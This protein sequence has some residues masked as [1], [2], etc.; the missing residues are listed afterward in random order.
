[1]F[2]HTSG[3][4]G[5]GARNQ[6]VVAHTLIFIRLSVATPLRLYLFQQL[7]RPVNG[8]GAENRKSV[9]DLNLKQSLHPFHVASMLRGAAVTKLEPL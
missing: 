5:F 9:S 8:A 3:F 1:V 2:G 4:G 7:A 6:C